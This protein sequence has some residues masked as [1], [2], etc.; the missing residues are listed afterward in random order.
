MAMR[1]EETWRWY[2]PNDPV[3]LADV[4]QSGATGVVTAL[5]DVPAGDVWPVEKIRARQAE[6][7]KAGLKWSVVESV[8]VHESIKLGIEPACTT[9]IDNYKQTLRNL[10]ECGITKLC[11]NFMPV[12]DWTRTDLEHVWED[13]SHALKFDIDEFAAFE[14]YILERP[15]AEKDYSAGVLGRAK[16]RYDAMSPA[17][18]DRLRDTV[19]AGLPGRMVDAYDIGAFKK[20]LSQYA[21][22]DAATLRANLCR[23]LREVVPVAEESGV[24]MAIHPDD[25][26]M[27]L[28]GLPRVVS[29]A[30]DVRALLAASDSVH[31]GITFCVGSYA[32]SPTND[33]E[34]M[35]TEFAGRTH[36]L[37]LRNVR[38]EGNE[39]S[40][41]ESDHLTG[42][43]DMYHVMNTFIE[44][45][46][47]RAAAGWKETEIPFRPDHGHKM[48]DD[49]RGKKTNPGYTA[50]GRLRG[51]A[52]LRGLQEGIVRAKDAAAGAQVAKRPRRG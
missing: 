6:V 44:E 38:K 17:E 24:F 50:I 48:L 52:E 29:T 14:L 1:L 22:V 41:C 23:F 2:G 36:F 33:V 10:G 8:P 39:G 46:A 32:S 43:V 3:T 34:A 47:K 21:N 13:G 40:F 7:E 31:N 49:L 15:G 27:N 26:P 37:H 45:R 25:P 42:D 19:I 5:H 18:R 4:R 12:I 28:L 51:L 11:Y 30:A 16:A 20:A 35:A 9:Y